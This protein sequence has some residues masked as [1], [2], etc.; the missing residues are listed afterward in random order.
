MSSLNT[1]KI[2]IVED[3]Q[4]SVVLL[5]AILKKEGYDV[6]I[7]HNGR[8]ALSLLE[9]MK[10]D[11]IICDVM[12]P[13]LNGYEFFK[14]VRAD[15]RTAEI[16]FIVLTAH[17]RIGEAFGE[18]DIEAMLN[19]PVDREELLEKVRILVSYGKKA[20]K[21][22]TSSARKKKIQRVVV[23]I[24]ALTLAALIASALFLKY[25]TSQISTGEAPGAAEIVE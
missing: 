10:P 5:D 14:R 3:E 4:T 12:M 21:F 18:M 24:A 7:A 20:A 17:T 25:L 19:K 16:P 15:A 2:L 6:V 22:M 9:G 1:K 13:E 8:V 11:L 23:I